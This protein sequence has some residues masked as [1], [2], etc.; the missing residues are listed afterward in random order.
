MRECRS[1]IQLKGALVH[2]IGDIVEIVPDRMFWDTSQ[3]TWN[4]RPL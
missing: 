2:L 4:D 1:N 3:G